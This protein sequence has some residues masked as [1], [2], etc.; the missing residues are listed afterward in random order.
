MSPS[1]RLTVT[2][3]RGVTSAMS[4]PLDS[5]FHSGVGQP[6]FMTAYSVW[7]GKVA[8]GEYSTWIM[9]SVDTSIRMRP[10]CMV[11]CRP[12]GSCWTPVTEFGAIHCAERPAATTTNASARSSGFC[13]N[14]IVSEGGGANGDYLGGGRHLA[15]AL[16]KMPAGAYFS[17]SGIPRTA[18][19]VRSVPGL[20]PQVRAG[21]RLLS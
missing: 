17:R 18:G 7:L 8:V 10:D 14:R 12:F 15:A 16:P 4:P 1:A 11:S 21:A 19:Y 6:V 5:I 13:I 20:R 9:E 2:F 3:N